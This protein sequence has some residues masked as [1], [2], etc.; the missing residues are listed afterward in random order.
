MREKK[1]LG[2]LG[3]KISREYLENKGYKI[4]DK[5]F[6]YSKLGEL[7][8]IA[9]KNNAIIFFEVKT[10]MKTGLDGFWPEDNITYGKQKKLIKLS[11]IYLSKKKLLDRDWQINVLAIELYR[12]GTYDIRHLENAVEDVLI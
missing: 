9:T 6:R 4:L 8:I 11:Q 10:R 1:D 12:D 7:D 5:N 3:E 2:D